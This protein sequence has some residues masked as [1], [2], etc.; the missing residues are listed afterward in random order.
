[1][2][3]SSLMS[4]NVMKCLTGIWLPLTVMLTAAVPADD[5]LRLASDGSTGVSECDI[6]EIYNSE[7]AGR[8]TAAVSRR[9]D[10]VEVETFLVPATLRSGTY[11]VTLTRKG[12]DLYRSL[13]GV[14]VKTRY[15][16]EYA[17]SQPSILRITGQGYNKGTV[18]F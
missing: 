9:G 6:E 1:M 14:Y 16:Y 18:V 15:C 2:R 8:G 11:E 17:Y 5:A 12:S 13:E 10:F 3:K 4:L 7:D